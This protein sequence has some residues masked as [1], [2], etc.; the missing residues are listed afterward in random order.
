M[1]HECL[2]AIKQKS[3]DKIL[4][5]TKLIKN[6]IRNYFYPRINTHEILHTKSR[7]DIK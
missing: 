3:Q 4:M 7:L 5:H 6:L 1:T 2:Y